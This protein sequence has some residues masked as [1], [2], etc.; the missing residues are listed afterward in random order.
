MSSKLASAAPVPLLDVNRGNH[1][2]RDE[3]LAAITQV[4]DSGKFLHGLKSPHWKPK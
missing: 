4:V 3:I 1:E 2:L